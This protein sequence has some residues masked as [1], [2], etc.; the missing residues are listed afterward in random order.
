[1]SGHVWSEALC[2][3]GS[4]PGRICVGLGPNTAITA[5]TLVDILH[6][7]SLGLDDSGVSR[8]I[9]NQGIGVISMGFLHLNLSSQPDAPSH[10]TPPSTFAQSALL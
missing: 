4:F 9:S 10:A 7:T 8:I 1:M 3:L 5:T 2:D 6:P